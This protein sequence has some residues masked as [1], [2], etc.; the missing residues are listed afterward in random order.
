VIAGLRVEDEGKAARN[1]E[2]KVAERAKLQHEK[3]EAFHEKVV[4]QVCA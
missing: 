4:H 1:L 3:E 2:K